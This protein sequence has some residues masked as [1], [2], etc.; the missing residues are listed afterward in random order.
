MLVM[1]E[2]SAAELDPEPEEKQEEPEQPEQE[3]LPKEPQHQPTLAQEQQQQQQQPPAQEQQQPQRQSSF[4]QLLHQL[5]QR[6]QPHAAQEQPQ[7]QQQ[8]QS[9]PEQTQQR[10]QAA[11]DEP[12]P[13]TAAA[14]TD[15]D[16]VTVNGRRFSLSEDDFSDIVIIPSPD[17]SERFEMV[18][19]ED[20]EEEE[21][22]EQGGLLDSVR[23]ARC[24]GQVTPV[25]PAGDALV[26]SALSD[27]W[28]D[29]AVSL[30]ASS[31]LDARSWVAAELPEDADAR[32]DSSPQRSHCESAPAACPLELSAPAALPA[33]LPEW[34]LNLLRYQ[35]E[36]G[37]Q[38]AV[39]TEAE[40]MIISRLVDMGFS[41]IVQIRALY[42]QYGDD[43]N[44]IASHLL[45]RS[46]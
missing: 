26:A 25:A 27:K 15:D 37:S 16:Y 13:E 23:E 3:T 4:D 5:S 36:R 45:D 6:P 17:G 41:D 9:S 21:E 22:E 11:V 34:V 43:C 39:P 33:L 32:R 29:A 31:E 42:C 24:D 28:C 2:H 30:E 44:A 19:E 18:E 46:V 38:E 40:A 35:H 10:S 8:P 20:E 7:L 14:E 1:V 12:E